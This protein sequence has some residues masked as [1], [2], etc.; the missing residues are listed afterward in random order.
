MKPMN[1]LLEKAKALEALHR[2]PKTPRAW[3]EKVIS[4]KAN[5][6]DVPEHFRT[7]VEDHISTYRMHAQENAIQTASER[8]LALPN[9]K[10]RLEAFNALPEALRPFVRERVHKLKK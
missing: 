1:D 4:E 7:I 6:E 2:T 8:I 5:I 3:A 10:L 9:G